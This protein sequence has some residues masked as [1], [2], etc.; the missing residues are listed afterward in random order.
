M[1][2]ALFSLRSASFAGVLA[3]A[4]ALLLLSAAPAWA[5]QIAEAPSTAAAPARAAAPRLQAS[6]LEGPEPTLDGQLDDA[7]WQRAAVATGFTQFSPDPGAPASFETEARVLYS[8]DAIFVAIQAYDPSP[9]S[10]VGQLTRRDQPSYSD[11]IGVMI[12]SYDDQRTAF[13]F[14]VNAVGVQ[15]DFYRFDDIQEDPGWDAVWGSAVAINAQGWAAEFRIPLS[16]LR[17]RDGERQR[18]GVNFFRQ[19]ARR[20]EMSAWS[21]T[22]QNDAAIVSKFGV[23]EGLS[24]VEAPRRLEILPYSVA[25]L[26]RAPGDASDPY[27]QSNDLFGSVGADVRFGVTNDLT[28]TLTLNPDFGQVEADPA[29]VNL[30]AFE[31]FLPERRPFF[32]EGT[33]FFDIG[34]SAGG[35]GNE[36]LFYSRRIGRAP[37]GQVDA[38]GGWT[39]QD[40]Q[41]TILGAW[42][43]SGKTATGWSIG[44]MHAVTAEEAA[45]ITP[46]AGTERSQAVEPFTNYSVARVQK[47][48]R[49]GRSALG[50]ISTG[51]NRNAGVASDLVLPS[52]A[53]TLGLDA[54]HRFAEDRWQ[55]SA[56]VIGSHVRGS[57]A[58]ILRLQQSATHLYQRPDAEHLTLDSTRT[59][60]SGVTWNADLQKF[61]GGNWR[62][63]LATQ[64]RTPGFDVNDAGYLREADFAGGFVYLGFDQPSP[65]GIFR[66]FRLNSSIASAWSWGGENYGV[67][68]SINGNAQF[69]NLYSLYG[70][71]FYSGPGLSNASLRGGPGLRRETSWNWWAGLNTDPRPALGLQFNG[72]GAVRP[73][74][75]SYSFGLSPSVAWRPSGRL[76]LDLGPFW[77]RN[78][79]DR[80]WV[81]RFGSAEDPG[82]L[83]GRIDQQTVGL[84]G[85]FSFAF[86]PTL[87]LQVY[88]Q[89]FV[90]AGRYVD[91]KTVADPQAPDYADRFT[92]LAHTR[93]SGQVSADLDGDGEADTF[94]SPDF[95][96][97]QFRSN[98]VLR[99]EYR[100]GSALFV[101]WAQGRDG[102]APTGDFDFGSDLGDLFSAPARNTFLV[103]FSY[104]LGG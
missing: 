52:G 88:A 76:N 56:F 41:T 14:D 26:D 57:E 48:F 22:S 93:A 31:V 43:L 58:S 75:D 5:Q 28:L 4:G 64:G 84:T 32:V 83:V 24:D 6:R 102:F 66:R 9:D 89:P 101:V 37:Q 63:T 80:Q 53:Y 98:T 90:S 30:S 96:V 8:D 15:R 97:R 79:D 19:I 104:W 23:L 69:S 39:D 35:E 25:R 16:Q 13:H 50:L 18:W 59:S 34:L 36:S 87:S 92:R 12:D 55:A 78:V 74:S 62:F 71:V 46:T 65:M 61:A 68:A 82:W 73:E 86:S 54:R 51:V 77:R 85:R 20:D 95:N 72:N 91:F 7:A 40:E 29:Q 99:W 11:V 81:G 17:F 44:L 21:P 1:R 67:N 10:I 47:D 94:S 38:D 45:Q 27:W 42:K 100:P 33:N 103:K 60:L 2:S 70:G 49:A 3:G